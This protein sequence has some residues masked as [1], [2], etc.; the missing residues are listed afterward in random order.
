[1]SRASP[2]QQALKLAGIATTDK[3]TVGVVTIR[4]F[5]AP[6]G[7]SCDA[8]LLGQSLGCLLTT[9]VRIGIQG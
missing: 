6:R 9:A 7:D 3:E 2:L 5:Y 1:M 8:Q 4:Q